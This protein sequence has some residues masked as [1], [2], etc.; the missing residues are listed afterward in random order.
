VA[1]GSSQPGQAA[2]VEVSAS[3]HGGHASAGNGVISEQGAAAQTV[4][5][6]FGR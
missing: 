6:R 2:L 3:R 5:L 4:A 1:V